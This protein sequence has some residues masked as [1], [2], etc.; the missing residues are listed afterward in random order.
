MIRIK[1]VIYTLLALNCF[2]FINL[3]TAFGQGPPPL[4]SP[5][6]SGIPI[7]GLEIAA[8]LALVI[9]LFMLIYKKHFSSR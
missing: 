3:H 2:L 5:P 4:P 9:C 7:G 1:T 8:I 6:S